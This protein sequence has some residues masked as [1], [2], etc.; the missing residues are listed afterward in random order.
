M[1]IVI[2]G[3]D[4]YLGWPTAL[5]FSR[6]G[7]EV[8]I[9]DNFS[10][11]RYVDDCGSDSITP[12][13]TLSERIS[14]WNSISATSLTH[15]FGD[16]ND[17]A[18]I[19]GVMRDFT[20][21]VIVH[22][23]E[24]PSAPW[25]MASRDH[26]VTTQVHN[27]VGTLNI[28]FAMRDHAPDCHL[29]KLGS[30][31]EYGTPNIVIEEGFLHVE[32]NGRSDTLPFPKQPG[33]F[34]HLSK[35]HD[36]HNI[37]FATKLWG[38]RATDLNQ[39]VVYG[40]LTDEIAADFKLCTRFDYDECFGTSFNRFCAQVV[41]GHPLTVY[42]LGGQTRG[43]L[44]IKDT[45]QCVLLAALNPPQ[46]GEYRV[47]NQFTEQYEVRS[48]AEQ[49]RDAAKAVGLRPEIRHLEDPRVEAEEHF[50]EARAQK[51][52]DLGLEP[53]LLTTDV[54]AE[55][56]ERL[57]PFRDR[58]A[59]DRITPTIRWRAA[60]L[61]GDPAYALP[62]LAAPFSSSTVGSGLDAGS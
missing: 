32:H 44:N 22:Y 40:L 61:D 16:V 13:D 17:Y 54:I 62:A 41:A 23:A 25:S 49:V 26:A 57:L 36:S 33:S 7:H 1:R 38:L 5:R 35:V 59:M 18:F 60:N 11:R 52:L 34:Y 53:T 14:R 4:G 31:G 19:S 3:G 47:F 27:V 37:A 10:R 46:S 45:V 28:L 6:L 43:F 55:I 51:I 48:L 56:L 9:I 42:G 30:M 8:M 29:I 21:Q 39:G 50:Y 24:Q 12:I 15:Q 58:I 20:P 2:L